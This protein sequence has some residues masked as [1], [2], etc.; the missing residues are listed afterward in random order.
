[1]SSGSTVAPPHTDAGRGVSVA[2]EVVGDVFAFETLDEF[3]GFGGLFF[4]T[5]CLIP[6]IY[7]LEANG[8]V[9]SG[10]GIFREEVDPVAG[11]NPVGNQ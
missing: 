1:M 3:L 7:D 2:A 10:G 4:G 9:R 5:E 6:G 11:F 8:G